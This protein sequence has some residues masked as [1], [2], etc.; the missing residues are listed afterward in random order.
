MVRRIKFSRWGL[1]EDPIGMFV[2]YSV[3]GRT[4]L[5]EVVGTYRSETPGAYTRPFSGSGK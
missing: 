5:R 3:N 1:A 2:S 4:K